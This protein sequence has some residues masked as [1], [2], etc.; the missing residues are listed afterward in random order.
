MPTANCCPVRTRR[1]CELFVRT[2]APKDPLVGSAH[3]GV[4]TY[5]Y[6]RNRDGDAAHF[7]RESGSLLLHDGVG[8]SIVPRVTR[9][10]EEGQLLAP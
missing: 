2:K 5:I 9:A 4:Q 7:H 6:V 3:D 1:L 8:H 10:G